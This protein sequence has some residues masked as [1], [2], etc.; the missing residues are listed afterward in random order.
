MSLINEALKTAQRERSE[1]S[2]PKSEQQVLEGFFPFIDGGA[3]RVAPS[4]RGLLLGG[5]AA[6]VLL[7]GAGS[8]IELA[9]LRHGSAPLRSIGR[10]VSVSAKEPPSLPPVQA[11]KPNPPQ[12]QQARKD[13]A[14]KP[15]LSAKAPAQQA[16]P[17]TAPVVRVVVA[18]SGA[19]RSTAANPTTSAVVSATIGTLNSSAGGVTL[20]GPPPRALDLR[21][22]QGVDAMSRGDYASASQIF[23]S[24]LSLGTPSRELHY[25]W[26]VTL[27]HLGDLDAAG[28]EFNKA[29]FVDPTWVL[30]MLGYA[31]VLNQQNNAQSATAWINKAMLLEP[32]NVHVLLAY[33]H[34]FGL[35]ADFSSERHWL[36]LAVAADKTN[37]TAHYNFATVLLGLADTTAAVREFNAA[38]RYSGSDPMIPRSKIQALLK[39]LPGGG[40]P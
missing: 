37:A 36:E 15:V 26:A 10:P 29:L 7:V 18:D 32:N 19:G 27:E 34:Q 12:P 9:R 8:A 23:Q 30:A 5:V 4:R 31:T 25:N 13:S 35:V 17:R 2:V 20:E 11:A 14:A 22:S 39:T 16:A 21:V 28:S 1:R 38:L 40:L 6:V 24:A 3:R 33:A